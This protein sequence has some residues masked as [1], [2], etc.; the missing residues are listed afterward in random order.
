MS[1]TTPRDS[2]LVTRG[3]PVEGDVKAT[4]IL[5][6]CLNGHGSDF[7]TL[8]EELVQLGCKVVCPSAPLRRLHWDQ[9]LTQAHS[10]YDYYTRRDGEDRHDI[11]N[12][13]HLAKECEY[14]LDVIAN[15]HSVGSKLIIGG[16]SQ[17]G[18]VIYHMLASGMVPQLTAAV[19]S[20]SCFL[21]DLV[22]DPVEQDV[23]LLVF[24]AGGDEVYSRELRDRGLAHLRKNTKLQL[25]E[26]CKSGLRHESYSVLENRVIVDFIRKFV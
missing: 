3:V 8:S 22:P 15:Y 11:I 13:R 12:R 21:H 19:I 16:V 17:G 7:K 14:V 10:W 1:R 20:R 6:H 5:L 2:P 24:S 23:S 26:M 25:A 18:T 9:A 4:I